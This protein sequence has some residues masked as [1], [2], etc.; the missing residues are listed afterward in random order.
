VTTLDSGHP[1]TFTLTAGQV[2]TV[3]QAVEELPFRVA[4]PILVSLRAQVVAQTQAD[5][6]ADGAPE[7][8]PA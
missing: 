2:A 3:M 7:T 5:G 4:A 6:K 1:M 8:P